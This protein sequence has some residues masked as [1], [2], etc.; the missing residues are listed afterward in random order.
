L[1]SEEKHDNGWNEN[2]SSDEIKLL[3]AFY[4]G[5]I[6]WVVFSVDEEEEK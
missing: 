1:K 6:V 3:D 4:S 5:E 2:A